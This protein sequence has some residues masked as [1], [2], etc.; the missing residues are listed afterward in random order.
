MTIEVRFS[1]MSP[2]AGVHKGT[3]G[4][5]PGMGGPPGP[6]RRPGGPPPGMSGPPLAFSSFAKRLD[7]LENKTVYLVDIGFGGGYNFMLQLQKWL[8]KNMPSVTTFV[9]RKPGMVF[10][11]DNNDLWEEVKAKGDAVVLGVAG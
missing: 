7:T 6:G 10:S 4:F 9:K 5:P 1:V 2:E 11:D 8:A 3:G